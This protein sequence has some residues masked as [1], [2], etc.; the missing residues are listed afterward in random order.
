MHFLLPFDFCYLSLV[1]V[2][3]RRTVEAVFLVHQHNHP[4]VL[5][6]QVANG[7]FKLPGDS[8]LSGEDELEGLS[9]RLSDKL[10]PL[11]AS[12]DDEP[13]MW[14]IGDCLAVWYRP[15]FENNFVSYNFSSF[16][17]PLYFSS[18]APPS[19][20]LVPLFAAAHYKAKGRKK[21][22]SRVSSCRLYGPIYPVTLLLTSSCEFFSCAFLV[23]FAVPKNLS[24]VA[25]PLFEL[26]DNSSRYGPLIASI[27]HLLSRYNILY[28]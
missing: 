18:H 11:A 1:L 22:V 2:G 8:L 28:C 16:S 27:P 25:V 5:L 3:L 7:Y 26:L 23:L 24:L 17:D 19:G 6:L 20:S 12:T 15:N 10:A 21:A 9:L 14:H 4:H 13:I